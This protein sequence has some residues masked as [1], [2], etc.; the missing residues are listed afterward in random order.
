MLDHFSPRR[1]AMV[2]VFGTALA[3]TACASGATRSTSST[4]PMAGGMSSA[5]GGTTVT[6]Q[7]FAFSPMRLKVAP[8]ATVTVTNKDSVAHT[9]TG[10]S[11]GFNTGDIPAG[12]STTFTAPTKPGTYSYLCNIHQYMTGTLTV[13]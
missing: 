7:N 11:G 2:T 3:L 10:S 9:L 12:Q 6:I 13:S 8:G 5:A 1:L 4:V